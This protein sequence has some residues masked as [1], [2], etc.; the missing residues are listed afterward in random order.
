[1]EA[2]MDGIGKQ[3]EFYRAYLP[4]DRGLLQVAVALGAV[5]AMGFVLYLAGAIG[6]APNPRLEASARGAAVLAARPVSR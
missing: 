2:V 4:H 1:M 6:P 5:L 3:A